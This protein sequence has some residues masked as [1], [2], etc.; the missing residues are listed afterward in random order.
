MCY[1]GKAMAFK[2]YFSQHASTYARHRPQYPPELFSWLASIAPSRDLAWDC[3]TGNGQAA[4]G[5]TPHFEYVVATDASKE[6]I[7]N[8]FA[9]ERLGYCVCTAEKTLSPPSASTW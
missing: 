4:L 7:R 5:L 2:D 8:A 9:G 1:T 6:Q 3:A